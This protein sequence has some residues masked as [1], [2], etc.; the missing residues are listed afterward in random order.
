MPTE[1]NVDPT[2][3]PASPAHLLGNSLIQEASE[4]VGV[5]A[6]DTAEACRRVIS[7]LTREKADLQQPPI[8]N[9][10]S[11]EWICKPVPMAASV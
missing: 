7:V 3:V 10:D 1:F 2:Y 6:L 4:V 8:S 5:T 9:P 11:D